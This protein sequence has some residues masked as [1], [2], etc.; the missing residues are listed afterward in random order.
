M[1]V[2]PHPAEQLVAPSQGQMDQA[3]MRLAKG[4]TNQQKLQTGWGGGTTDPSASSLARLHVQRLD[5][6]GE[7][8]EATVC[9]SVRK[10]GKP[11]S[12]SQAQVRRPVSIVSIY[13]EEPSVLLLDELRRGSQIQCH[14]DGL[15]DH[16][17]LQHVSLDGGSV[18]AGP[19][20]EVSLHV[21]VAGSPL[22]H[23]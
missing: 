10:E 4:H 18:P 22:D 20:L 11:G 23:V 21:M 12:N 14:P 2:E 7:V 5:D 16:R 13:P 1:A 19:F 3:A 8:G 17:A 15:Y 6:H 9:I